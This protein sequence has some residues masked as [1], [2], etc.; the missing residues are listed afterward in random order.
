MRLK[1]INMNPKLQF[2][3]KCNYY[4]IIT[5]NNEIFNYTDGR[6]DGVRVKRPR[7][8]ESLFGLREP[9]QEINHFLSD[10]PDE[11]NNL[12]KNLQANVPPGFLSPSVR[13]YLELGKSIPGMIKYT[14]ILCN[15]FG[16]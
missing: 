11:R 16:L 12:P 10:N 14:Y 4:S 3:K 1:T 5:N 13:E 8:P 15:F 9:P 2:I 7:A 6:E